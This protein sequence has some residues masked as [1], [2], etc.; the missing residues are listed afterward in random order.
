M[1]VHI[2]L[3]AS[4]IGMYTSHV[5]P[6]LRGPWCLRVKYLQWNTKIDS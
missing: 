3:Y 4:F 2:L 6:V 1:L 5:R